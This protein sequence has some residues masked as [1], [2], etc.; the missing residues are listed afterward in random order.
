[1]PLPMAGVWQ[2]HLSALPQADLLTPPGLQLDGLQAANY[3]LVTK[4]P[5]DVMQRTTL[6]LSPDVSGVDQVLQPGV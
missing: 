1:M 2:P 6:L 3:L 4:H 5:Q